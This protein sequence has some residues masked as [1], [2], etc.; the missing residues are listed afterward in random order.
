MTNE[1]LKNKIESK[2]LDDSVL[3]MVY[4]ECKFICNTYIDAI[5]KYK[6]LEKQYINSIN[7]IPDDNDFYEGSDNVLY[8][9]DVE[10]LQEYPTDQK[11]LIIITKSVPDNL[12]VDYVEM[13]EA[14]NDHIISYV[15][16]RL[17]GLSQDMVNWLCKICK[18][19]VYRLDQEC[20]KLEQFP[21]GSQQQMFM[22]MN[23][24]NAYSDL[25]ENNIFNFTNAIMK[26]EME[27]I[28]SLIPELDA[29]DLEP[30]GC[31]TILLNK[32]KKMVD[33]LLNPK[34]T[35]AS[36]GMTDKQF[37]FLKKH[38]ENYSVFSADKV[39]KNIEF[40][41]NLDYQIKSGN[42]DLSREQ[43]LSYIVVNVL[44]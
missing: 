42:L 25:S 10:K 5:C 13:V 15:S 14:S 18:Y 28:G 6:N 41:S 11:N 9:L 37:W 32:F 36:C 23:Q 27:T 17:K 21:E 16:M 44:A 29:A 26:K 43:L 7:D 3:I 1:Q 40:L 35:A 8:I 22:L 31:V 19:D 38:P 30:L 4:K 20:K 39:I 24:D 33:F 12:D 2:T 34:A